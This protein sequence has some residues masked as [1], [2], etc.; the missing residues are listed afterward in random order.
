MYSTITNPYTG[1]SVSI[2]T[3]IGK[4]IL[5][6]Y[7]T[8]F[9][10]S[11]PNKGE[12]KEVDP[13][14]VIEPPVFDFDWKR[15]K[16]MTESTLGEITSNPLNPD[17][18]SISNDGDYTDSGTWIS[19][20]KSISAPG[21]V[22][23]IKRYPIRITAVDDKLG[24]GKYKLEGETH[25]IYSHIIKH[26]VELNPTY[27]LELLN[28]IKAY[29]Y[30]KGDT[31]FQ[32][33]R[34]LSD[35]PRAARVFQKTHGDAR[36][37]P[38][39]DKPLLS[40]QVLLNTL[41]KINDDILLPKR[42]RSTNGLERCIFEYYINSAG[43]KYRNLI[44]KILTNGNTFKARIQAQDDSEFDGKTFDNILTD[45]ENVIVL[46]KSYL[47]NNP[48]TSRV[49]KVSKDFYQNMQYRI[50]EHNE[51]NEKLNYVRT[52]LYYNLETT[53]LL[54]LYVY[55]PKKDFTEVVKLS[56]NA[57]R[58]IKKGEKH[59]KEKK[60]KNTQL[61]LDKKAL[62]KKL[63][64]KKNTNKLNRIEGKIDAAKK[65]IK[66]NERSIKKSKDEETKLILDAK[67]MVCLTAEDDLTY[68]IASFYPVN[69]PVDSTKKSTKF[70]MEE[71]T[72]SKT[73]KEKSNENVVK[74]LREI[75]F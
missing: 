32:S 33:N 69:K 58:K 38:L 27:H 71:F 43:N 40:N 57:S 56:D 26:F 6:K 68:K 36:L 73:F 64:D 59:R 48:F 39:L 23:I 74:H 53:H 18:W 13:P 75:V 5:K 47:E 45:S 49:D 14:V 50:E 12:I 34:C 3:N 67:V 10:G 61:K 62:K 42:K 2:Y 17:Y 9:G 20:S 41:D 22:A 70:L 28:N 7:L 16:Q 66:S 29:L 30:D 31:S 55:G 15:Q 72:L 51:S 65:K 11:N 21:H 4:N 54:V 46:Y 1:H 37:H 19:N 60:N 8:Q 35:W 24:D 63:K 52:E 44:K 25:H